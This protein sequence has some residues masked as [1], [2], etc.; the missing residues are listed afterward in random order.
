MFSSYIK[1]ALRN[2]MKHRLY[3]CINI[4]GLGIGLTVF[5]FGNL[6]AQYEETHDGMFEHRDRIYTISAVF[7]ATANSSVKQSD[8]V[9]S[10]VGPL[11]ETSIPELEAVVRV[12]NK[13]FLVSNQ[14]QNYYENIRFVDKDFT[15]VFDFVYL[16]GD[17]TVLQNPKSLILTESVAQKLF[18]RKDVI[19][20]TLDFDHKNSLLVGAVIKDIANNSHFNSAIFDD[21]SLS[22]IASMK[23]LNAIEDYPMEGEW[24]NISFGDFTYILLPESRDR[25][26]LQA[27]LD[28]FYHSHYREEKRS[29]IDR[30]LVSP[31]IEV[32]TLIWD[33]VGLPMLE[34][35]RI[36]GLL[37][38]IIACVNY[39][40]LAS[41]QSL[42]R[43]KEV[44]LRKTFGA[45]RGQLLFQFL[46]E[47]VTTATLAII[48][49]VAALEVVTP[50]FNQATGK[51][52]ALDYLSI[53]PWLAFTAL[54]TGLLAGAYPALLITQAKPIESLKGGNIALGGK[55]F[56]SVMMGAQFAISFFMLASVLTLYF[57]NQSLEKA[58]QLFAK[59]QILLLDRVNVKELSDHHETLRNEL[60]NIDGVKVVSYT[61]QVPFEQSNRTGN[62]T[63]VSGDLSLE[64]ST[65]LMSIDEHFLD[66]YDITLLAG[67]N[68]QNNIA[69]DTD[70]DGGRQTNVLIN[71]LLAKKLG[72]KDNQEALGKS[73]YDTFQPG[74]QGEVI[75]YIIVGVV[76]TQN[77]LGLHNKV[78]PFLFRKRTS[79]HRIA[80]L[81]I[82]ATN[83]KQTLQSI[84]DAW[85]KV[86]PDY[87]IQRS[88]LN[89]KFMSVYFIFE[90]TTKVLGGF[91]LVALSLALIGLFG[92]AAF[93]AER[94]TKE[95]GIRK[96]LGAHTSQIVR[97]LIW[98]FSVPVLWSLV[99]A[100]P[101]AYFIANAYLNFFSERIDFVLPI[102]ILASV[103]GVASAWGVVSIHAF[104]IART[105][106]IRSLRYE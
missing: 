17:K 36:L 28:Q 19:G 106:P 22:I 13:E 76:P 44:G 24:N 11:L 38:L 88:F 105:R 92:L 99:V 95:I 9:Q 65:N 54:T 3:A 30:L 56:R 70:G 77:F 26:W 60:L 51:V 79:E 5:L 104:R 40:N 85:G 96:V 35:L 32:N 80:S 59:D 97:L 31:L 50:L 71:E 86:N 49:S 74:D 78:K 61:N 87:P 46:T 66:A 21:Q 98:Q 58:S 103:M 73:I 55:R 20:E 68:I 69:N 45:S 47:S 43:T 102:L 7:N 93:L 34:S 72:Y 53:A 82:D 39:T 67:R 75:E 14:N 15:H 101:A 52:V 64:L 6:I 1:L 89:S 42:S 84:N 25:T 8:S 62:I 57:Q 33:S 100:V 83:M 94:R 90:Q 18:G 2:L 23:A 91:S 48:V 29:F 4:L 63:P 16:Y 12:L 41:A 81:L 27:Q 37:V 10:A